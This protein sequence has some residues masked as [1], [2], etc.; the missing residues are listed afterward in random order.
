MLEGAYRAIGTNAV[1]LMI[2]P[3]VTTEGRL[4]PPVE[5]DRLTR[6]GRTGT[7]EKACPY[8]IGREGFARGFTSSAG[9]SGRRSRWGAECWAP[10]W[11]GILRQSRPP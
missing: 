3:S 9:R 7:E 2:N 5:H 1:M 11:S 6:E 4:S 8:R 10:C